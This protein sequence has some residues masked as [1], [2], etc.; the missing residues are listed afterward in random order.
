MTGLNAITLLINAVMLPL[1]LAFLVIILWNDVRKELN[2]F[3]AAFLLLVILWNGGSL[4]AQGLTLVDRA[5]AAAQA[6]DRLDGAGLHR[7]ERGDLR[8]DRRDRQGAYSPLSRAGVGRVCWCLLIVRLLPIIANAP[9]SFVT[10]AP[11]SSV[12][13][14]SRCWS[15]ST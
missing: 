7:V 6:D 8:P 9:S 2:Q 13:N 14:R 10:I 1:A 15:C 3:F 4:L 5:V 11:A 12:I